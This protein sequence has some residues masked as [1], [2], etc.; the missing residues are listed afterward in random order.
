M[1]QGWIAGR[2]SGPLALDTLHLYE[3]PSAQRGSSWSNTPEGVLSQVGR[4]LDSYALANAR[5]VCKPWRHAFSL[6]IH[7]ARLEVQEHGAGY[8]RSFLRAFKRAF[9]ATNELVLEVTFRRTA[10]EKIQA[11]LEEYFQAL[12]DVGLQSLQLNL[13]LNSFNERKIKLPDVS[14]LACWRELTRLTLQESGW[15]SQ[16]LRVDA[17]TVFASLPSL[18]ELS[19]VCKFSGAVKARWWRPPSPAERLAARIPTWPPAA[20]TV[21]AATGGTADVDMSTDDGVAGAGGSHTQQLQQQRQPG[22]HNHRQ[23]VA[24]LQAQVQAVAYPVLTQHLRCQMTQNQSMSGELQKALRRI[25]PALQSHISALTFEIVEETYAEPAR[26]PSPLELSGLPGLKSL[27][28]LSGAEDALAHSK[29][30]IVGASVLESLVIFDVSCG[31]WCYKKPG[32]GIPQRLLSSPPVCLR[33][34]TVVG[35]VVNQCTNLHALSG[36]A[37][38]EELR[39]E[40]PDPDSLGSVAGELLLTWLPPSLRVLKLH[41]M[42][43]PPCAATAAAAA[44]PGAGADATELLY[45][46]AP[47]APLPR[48]QELYLSKCKVPTLGVLGVCPQLTSLGV[49]NCLSCSGMLPVASAMPALCSLALIHTLNPEQDLGPGGSSPSPVP[50][51]AGGMHHGDNGF[52]APGEAHGGPNGAVF[53]GTAAFAAGVPSMAAAATSQAAAP[54]VSGLPLPPVAWGSDEQVAA[55]AAC[56][57]V[58]SLQLIVPRGGG[59]AAGAAIAGG[60]SPAVTAMAGMPYLKELDVCLPCGPSE[61][62]MGLARLGGSRRTG[63]PLRRLTIWV[64]S[65]TCVNRVRAQQLQALQRNLQ[66]Q[67]PETLVEWAAAES[68]YSSWTGLEARV[69]RPH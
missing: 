27:T 45:G 26:S 21:R 51:A 47:T 41:A 9:P 6:D 64:D 13:D 63:G 35:F 44:A 33:S 57:T 62:M 36:L 32:H 23:Q 61:W 30:D 37:A 60:G 19:V 58:T 5:A 42:V 38:L 31:C 68:R 40:Q 11:A 46:I 66:A 3:R 14:L 67:M 50:V 25:T 2:G 34:L 12:Q 22:D 43:L 1:S 8:A 65:R 15:R 49:F 24:A 18:Q 17:G 29:L 16:Q 52:A 59:A 54:N 53:G 55:M 20:A 56:G 7:S 4:Y 69:F 48:L 39:L 10:R 28:V